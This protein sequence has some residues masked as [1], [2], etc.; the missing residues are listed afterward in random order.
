MSQTA[1]IILQMLEEMLTFTLTA[2][3]KHGGNAEEISMKLSQTHRQ[4][5]EAMEKKAMLASVNVLSTIFSI[6][7]F[8]R[9][10]LSMRICSAEKPGS[11]WV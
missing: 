8:P 4:K 1:D 5:S 10:A 3:I 6:S 7:P 9:T 11:F 2:S